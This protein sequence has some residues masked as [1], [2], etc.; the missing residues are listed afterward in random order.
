MNIDRTY[1]IYIC[2]LEVYISINSNNGV[3]KKPDSKMNW[4]SPEEV[5]LLTLF[6]FFFSFFLF[7]WDGILVKLVKTYLWN[8]YSHIPNC[9][10]FA[11]EPSCIVIWLTIPLTSQLGSPTKRYQCPLTLAL[12]TCSLSLRF[13][14]S[15]ILT[16]PAN[17]YWKKLF[18]G[19][20]LSG[21]CGDRHFF[22]GLKLPFFSVIDI[23]TYYF[24]VRPCVQAC[25]FIHVYAGTSI[26]VHLCMCASLYVMW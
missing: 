19:D 20:I 14:L 18:G 3:L 21:F 26:C 1:S 16:F 15:L 23:C 11:N 17:W 2:V 4:V 25:V 12:K 7:L 10:I 9:C 8:G 5:D 13:C 24:Y 6:V 22:N